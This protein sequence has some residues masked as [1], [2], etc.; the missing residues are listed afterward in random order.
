MQKP[1]KH[2]FRPVGVSISRYRKFVSTLLLGQHLF[3][4]YTGYK[5]T[6]ATINLKH[7][8]NRSIGAK[9]KMSDPEM[10]YKAIN[11]LEPILS[12][13]VSGDIYLYIPVS[14]SL[15]YY[16]GALILAITYYLG[17]DFEA[18]INFNFQ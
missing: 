16:E 2:V 15:I 4:F 7:K 18:E 11:Y 3:S 6:N 8:N 17:L 9:Y 14:F 10:C 1:L 13:E 5:K 12:L